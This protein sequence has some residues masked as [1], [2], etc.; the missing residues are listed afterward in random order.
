MDEREKKGLFN[1]AANRCRASEGDCIALA[2]VNEAQV[3]MSK[4]DRTIRGQSS[5]RGTYCHYFV[6]S[7]R[8]RYGE[9]RPMDGR[10]E[11]EISGEMSDGGNAMPTARTAR[12]CRRLWNTK[13]IP[14]APLPA[15]GNM[16]YGACTGRVARGV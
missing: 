10:E 1:F 3:L 8:P 13:T 16:N 9:D 11:L 14:G 4:T 12:P 2:H 5:V 7:P 15:D 6:P